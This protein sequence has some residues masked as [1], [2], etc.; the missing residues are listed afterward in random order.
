MD[1]QVIFDRFGGAKLR[2]FDDCEIVNFAGQHL[3]FL[4][5]NCVFNYMG[6]QVGWYEGGILRDLNGNTSGFS[7]NPT[8][9]P[10]PLLPLR[11]LKPLPHLTELKPLKPL[12]EIRHLKPLKSFSWSQLEPEQLFLSRGYDGQVS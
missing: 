10:H 5:D 11:Q 7:E 3:G 1:T 9:I 8:D 12:T 6:L 4:K 2:I